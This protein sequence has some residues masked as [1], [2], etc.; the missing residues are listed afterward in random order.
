MHLIDSK[1]TTR[2][3]KM[4]AIRTSARLLSQ[5]EKNFRAFYNRIKHA[6]TPTDVIFRKDASCIYNYI[7]DVIMRARCNTLRH[8]T[9]GV[10]NPNRGTI[11]NN[12]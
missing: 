10:K 2:R 1:K 4:N 9:K 5:T 6:L 3:T 7:R 8:T 12:N 11:C